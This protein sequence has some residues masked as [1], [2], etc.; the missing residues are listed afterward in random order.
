[1]LF[2]EKLIN[3][4]EVGKAEILPFIQSAARFCGDDDAGAAT[5]AILNGCKHFIAYDKEKPLIGYSLEVG[6]TELFITQAAGKANF[7]IVEIGLKIIELQAT[8]FKSVAFKTIRRG[9]IKKAIKRGYKQDGKILR[10]W[11]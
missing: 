11:L 7:D 4:R 1:M 2:P 9:L 8:H 3:L 10:K 5:N 6:K